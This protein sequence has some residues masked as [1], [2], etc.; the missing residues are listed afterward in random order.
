[1]GIGSQRPRPVSAKNADGEPSGN[2]M[3]GEMGQPAFTIPRVNCKVL[4][5]VLTLA[6]WIRVYQ[7]RQ[8]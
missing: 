2:E 7:A 1:M 3:K 5:D 8:R 6:A 4:Q